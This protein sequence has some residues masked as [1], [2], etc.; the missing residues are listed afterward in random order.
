MKIQRAKTKVRKSSGSIASTIPAGLAQLLGIKIGSKIV[1]ELDP[2]GE[3]FLKV[4][5]DKDE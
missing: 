5:L 3:A 2:N 1:W 4:Y